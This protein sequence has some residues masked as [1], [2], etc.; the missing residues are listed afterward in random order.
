MKNLG[1][2]LKKILLST[3]DRVRPYYYDHETLNF[4][5]LDGWFFFIIILVFSFS[6]SIGW[7]FSSKN[8]VRKRDQYNEEA[9]V[10]IIKN[11]D[12]FNENKLILFIKELN[13]RFPELVYAQSVLESGADFDSKINIENNNYFG[14]KDANK[15]INIQFG[16][17]N[18]HAY[19]FSWRNSVIDYA[20]FAATYLSDFKSKEEYYQYIERNY[21]ETPGYIERVK[22][23]EK[24]YFDKLSKLEGKNSYD[25][26]EEETVDLKT[27]KKKQKKTDSISVE[28]KTTDSI[29]NN[30]SL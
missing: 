8:E 14:M 18:D 1:I 13:F 7:I 22:F 17:Q 11:G 6:F 28:P 21:S 5:R 26:F 20:L 29:I 10:M 16:T 24:Q 19:Y 9:K 3:K 23:L 15:R 30:D 4:K 27:P 12:K 25:L 2:T